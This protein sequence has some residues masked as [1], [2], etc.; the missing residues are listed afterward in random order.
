[1]HACESAAP[2]LTSSSTRER[3]LPNAA[4]SPRCEASPSA[5]GTVSPARKSAV[6]SWLKSANSSG[7]TR[8]PPRSPTPRR[9]L[10]RCTSRPR[11]PSSSRSTSSD[12]ATRSPLTVAPFSAMATYAYS[13]TAPALPP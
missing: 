6:N 2:F 13:G 11:P 4:L 7:L 9:A 1:M 12:G 3:I 8:R 10:T 5:S